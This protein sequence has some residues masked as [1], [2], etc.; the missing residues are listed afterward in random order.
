M[1]NENGS[2]RI[3]VAVQLS[4]EH[5]RA[6]DYVAGRLDPLCKKRSNALRHLIALGLKVFHQ[7]EAASIPQPPSMDM[8]T[9]THVGDLGNPQNRKES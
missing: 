3:T 8:S 6:I 7:Q 9:V 4:R 2:E 1:A 5:V